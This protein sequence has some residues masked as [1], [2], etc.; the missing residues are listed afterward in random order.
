MKSK[1][2][3]IGSEECD[4]TFCCILSLS[5]IFYMLSLALNRLACS[6]ARHHLTPQSPRASLA[7]M[8][9]AIDWLFVGRRCA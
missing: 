8:M 7:E 5:F 1:D 2:L 3:E 9:A 6:R 4:S